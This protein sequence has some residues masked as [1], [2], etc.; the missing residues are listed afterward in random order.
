MYKVLL[1]GNGKHQYIQNFAIWL[2][3]KWGANIEI[4]ILT[5]VKIE[6]SDKENGIYNSV[7]YFDL[8]PSF[9]FKIPKLGEL[10]R[11]LGWYS[12]QY[13][14]IKKDYDIC[15]IHYLHHFL[16]YGINYL[17]KRCKKTV[18]TIWGNDFNGVIGKREKNVYY[19]LNK[20]DMVTLSN[21]T[22]KKEIED[23]SDWEGKE[24]YLTKYGLSPLDELKRLN[25]VTR[26]QAKS[27]FGIDSEKIIIT[28]G[29]SN[30]SEHKQLALI[31]EIEKLPA[32]IKNN[33]CVFFPMTYGN[34]FNNLELVKTKLETSSF[35][36]KVYES[37]LS[38]IEVAY[39]RFAS[40]IFIHIVDF[41]QLS[42]SMREYLYTKNIV[43]TG[44]WLPYESLKA[45]GIYFETIDYP[46]EIGDRLESIIRNLNDFTEA[47]TNNQKIIKETESWEDVIR[48][49]IKIYQLNV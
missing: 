35:K 37:Y 34:E 27:Y 9:L 14:Q 42:G 28:C 47:L 15:H 38:D 18:I 41:D 43:I 24:I 29:Y 25:N 19:L 26:A 4:D 49:W 5:H 7:F 2:R 12:L 6:S 33:L 40:D 45:K 31:D 3:K 39:L 23:N 21:P 48:Y 10:I 17:K 46:T 16:F 32:N 1:V 30:R 13:R 8:Y 44:S 11:V 36:Y 20:S 22:M